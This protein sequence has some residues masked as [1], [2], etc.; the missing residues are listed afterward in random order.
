MDQTYG[1]STKPN[2]GGRK[3]HSTPGKEQAERAKE[4][5]TSV[6]TRASFFSSLKKFTTGS[7]SAGDVLVALLSGYVVGVK[8]RQ[9]WRQK[10][11]PR[12]KGGW[13]YKR[14]KFH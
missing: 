4:R 12:D 10:F 13:R 7:A 9:L 11:P 6:E 2:A 1:A 3:K 5:Q 14:Y 8:F